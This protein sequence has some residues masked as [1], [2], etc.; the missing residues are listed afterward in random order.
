V[1]AGRQVGVLGAEHREGPDEDL[2]GLRRARIASGSS[3]SAI[4]RRKITF[5][6]PSAPITAISFVGQA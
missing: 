1:L 5:A 4:C 2:A 3:A 6:A